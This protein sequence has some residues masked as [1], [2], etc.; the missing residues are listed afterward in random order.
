MRVFVTGGTGLLGNT[1]LRQLTDAGHESAALVRQ[2][3]E[4]DVFK[5]IDTEFVTG[6]LLDKQL[7]ETAV[8]NCDA[9]IHAAGLIHIGWQRL[10]ESMRVNGEGTQVMVDACLRNR[11]K[12]IYVGTVNTLA[13]G[14]RERPADETTDPTNG[15][16]QVPCSYVVSKRAGVE[17]VKR[18]VA[19]GLQAVILCPGFML[20]PWDWKPSSGRM[21]IA[22][23]KGWKVIAPNG[24]CSVCDVRDVAAATIASIE[25]DLPSGRQFI[26]AGENM[27]YK[28]LWTEIARRFSKRPPLMKAGLLQ[29]WVAGAAGDTIARFAP[30]PD[31]N[32][33]GVR[34]SSQYHWYDSTRAREELDYRPRHVDQS[35]DAA[36]RWVKEHQP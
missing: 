4:T 10:G 2:Q 1:I 23:S 19:R 35:I 17:E 22:L 36:A 24:G 21:M 25:K 28:Q 11:K 26:L 29:C 33:A 3:P 27:T 5:G 32:S 7:I 20:G 8:Q 14:S 13:V 31:F 18:G 9:V 16:G 15:G 6:D 12:L 34:M 30:E